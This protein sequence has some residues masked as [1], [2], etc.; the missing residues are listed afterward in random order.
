MM[1]VLEDK[2]DFIFHFG[3]M[4]MLKC[5]LCFPSIEQ[6]ISFPLFEVSLNDSY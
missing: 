5:G 4:K 3:N 6:S 1:K 2:L